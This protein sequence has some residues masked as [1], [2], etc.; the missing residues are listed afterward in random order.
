M[1]GT[2][3][4]RGTLCLLLLEMATRSMAVE[5]SQCGY[6]DMGMPSSLCIY[7]RDNA[8]QVYVCGRLCADLHNKQM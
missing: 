1:Q 3:G 8:C 6:I 4:T 5:K 7:D 2:R